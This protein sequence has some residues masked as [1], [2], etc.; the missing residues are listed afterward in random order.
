MKE[1]QLINGIE[2]FAAVPT[3][4]MMLSYS[5]S[6]N[7]LG[8]VAMSAIESGKKWAGRRWKLNQSSPTA[9]G[10]IGDKEFLANFPSLIGLGGYLVQNDHSR[11]KLNPSN[12]YL[13]IDG[14][15]ARIDGSMGH[16]QWG[17]GC[18]F[19]YAEWDDDT[20]H[21]EAVSL[22]PISGRKNWLIPVASRSCAGKATIDRTNL[23][24]VSFCN[25]SAQYRGGNNDSSKDGTY[26]TQIGMA[27]TNMSISTFETYARKNGTRWT[28]GFHGMIYI[29]AALFRV[30]MGTR[31]V[32]A[33]PTPG[34][35]ADGIRSG[36]LGN[37]CTYPSNWSSSGGWNYYPFVPLSAGAELGDYT[38]TFSHVI[39]GSDGAE[40]TI[41]GIPSFFGLKN[42]YKYIYDLSASMI[43]YDNADGTMDFYVNTKLDATKRPLSKDT[44]TFAGQ[45]VGSPENWSYPSKV[46]NEYLC[47][48]ALEI[49]GSSSTYYCDGFYK[50][51]NSAGSRLCAFGGHASHG[52]HAGALCLLASTAVSDAA[53]RCGAFLC[54]S[55]VDWD[56]MG[57]EVA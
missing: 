19:Y 23:K 26:R 14:E 15:E 18:T 16:Y 21:N 37:G 33:N 13:T 52:V 41:T 55:V 4:T 34:P 11:V 50:G 6:A 12:H 57:F 44:M 56:T 42:F 3:D 38:G 51:S 53:A 25:T 20:Y 32:Q 2:A 30:I 7:K 39:T 27:A 35:D 40:I 46:G 28:A 8:F 22:S 45:G 24:M 5:P 9:E 47:P 48:V 29:T 17:W 10:I 43:G 49:L 31:N 36:G 1:T 54:E